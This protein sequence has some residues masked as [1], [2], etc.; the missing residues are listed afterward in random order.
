LKD[1]NGKL[2]FENFE[3][4]VVVRSFYFG[5]NISP[6]LASIA[7]TDSFESPF[8]FIPNGTNEYE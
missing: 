8:Y 3:I 5:L 6:P 2:D 1:I 7:K 4:G